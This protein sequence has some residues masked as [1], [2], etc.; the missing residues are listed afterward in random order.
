MIFKILKIERRKR[1]VSSIVLKIERRK[2]NVSSKVLKIERR[3]RHQ[4]RERKI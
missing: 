2:R 3:T 1:N 4:D